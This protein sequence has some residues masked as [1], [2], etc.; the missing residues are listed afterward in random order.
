MGQDLP[1]DSK[2]LTCSKKPFKHELGGG[3]YW[4]NEALHTKIDGFGTRYNG[5]EITS[6]KPSIFARRASFSQYSPPP[7][8]GGRNSP[9][10]QIAPANTGVR[11]SPDA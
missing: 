9:R 2:V 8:G 4:E 10:A 3:E 5:D 7:R 6:A 1:H 11:R